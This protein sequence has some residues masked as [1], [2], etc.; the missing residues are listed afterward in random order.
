MSKKITQCIVQKTDDAVLMNEETFAEDL[1][2]HFHFSLGRDKVQESH[3]YLYN[4][5][6]LSLIHI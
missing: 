3:D 4:A 6:A 2:R 5:L 1:A